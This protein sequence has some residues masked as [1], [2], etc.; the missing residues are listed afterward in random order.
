[1]L[2][3]N[4]NVVDVETDEQNTYG[5]HTP[6]TPSPPTTAP[7]PTPSSSSKKRT[8]FLLVVCKRDKKL[9]GN[10]LLNTWEKHT[11]KIFLAPE[12]HEQYF[13]MNLNINR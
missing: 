7:P 13:V 10:T 8:S 11:G 2:R 6:V 1:M 3:R 9:Y 12:L 5:P 4:R